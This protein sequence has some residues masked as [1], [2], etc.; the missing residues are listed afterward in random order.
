MLVGCAPPSA[1]AKPNRSA[2]SENGCETSQL[3]SSDYYQFC[4]VISKEAVDQVTSIDGLKTLTMTSRGGTG[5]EA[6]RLANHLNENN[7]QL[8]LEEYCLS[9]CAQFL[10]LGVDD[11]IVS[12]GTIAGFHHSTLSLLLRLA[13]SKYLNEERFA[14]FDEA[15]MRPEAKFYHLR[16]INSDW[17]WIPDVLLEPRCTQ[18]SIFTLLPINGKEPTLGYK[19]KYIFIV[20]SQKILKQ[21]NPNIVFKGQA[22]T[23]V[24]ISRRAETEPLAAQLLKYIDE[25]PDLSEE[26]AF[27]KLSLLPLCDELQDGEKEPASSE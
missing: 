23:P 16:G 27:K 9:A 5:I 1:I 10:M 4:G 15:Y 12:D 8:I 17:L 25:I 3:V 7:I 26:E 18:V 22:Q 14:Y 11:V 21:L 24:A 20:P 19:A 6:I 13:H 2:V